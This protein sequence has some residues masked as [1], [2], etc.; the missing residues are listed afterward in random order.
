[1]A[2]TAAVDQAFGAPAKL[3]R[4]KLE[5]A[6]IGGDW[7]LAVIGQARS[8]TRSQWYQTGSTKVLSS[9]VNSIKLDGAQPEVSLTNCLDTSKL[10]I[11]F[12][13]DG[14]PVP[15]G[16]GN[17]TRHK[18]VSRLVYAPPAPGG[19]KIWF[20]VSDKVSGKC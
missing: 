8:F 17:G 4:S 14:K 18:F 19:Q 20:L 1:V 6:G 10:I 3:D 16:A 2:A 5:K 15:M 9:K 11:R 7:I 12:A 13:K